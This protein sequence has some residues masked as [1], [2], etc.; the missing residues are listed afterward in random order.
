MSDNAS[1]EEQKKWFTEHSQED[2]VIETDAQM[3]LLAGQVKI[4][5]E[6]FRRA[7]APSLAHGLREAAGTTIT[8]EAIAEAEFGNF[9]W[10][11]SV[12]EKNLKGRRKTGVLI[13]AAL[14][15]SMVGETERSEALITKL[16]QDFPE[17]TLIN[18][19]WIPI[20]KAANEIKHGNPSKAIALL[21]I[22]RP[23]EAGSAAAFLPAY[24][25]GQ[26][27]LGERDA[28]SAVNEFQKILEHRGVDPTSELYV[29]AHLELARAWR[30]SDNIEKSRAAYKDFLAL[31]RDADPDI[32]ILVEGKAEYAK[33]K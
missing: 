32:P 20:A 3:A 28:A 4:A 7:A 11:K 9:G 2:E 22:A 33:L 6:R 16:N 24:L 19:V 1:A 30:L 8:D 14:V 26:A 29:L 31:W 21:E 18:G 12:I 17:D 27:Y 10:A 15:F 5:R 25:R 23:Y 13:N